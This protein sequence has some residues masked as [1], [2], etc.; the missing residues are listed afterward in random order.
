MDL[1][2]LVSVSWWMIIPLIVLG[3]ALHFVYDWSG[4]RRAVA[5]L[6][7][8]NESYWEHIKIAIW[9]IAL[10]QLVLFAAGGHNYAAFVP[11]ATIALYSVPISMVGIVFLYKAL[12][13]RNVLWVDI[14]VFALVVALAQ[15]I[16]IKLLGQLA[17]DAVTVL[18]AV[19]FLTGLVGAFLR[20][21][22][23]PPQEPDV[24]RDP[25]T[26]RYGL[27]G[28]SAAVADAGDD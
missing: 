3:S 21:T 10:T 26:G 4:Q 1:D 20:F 22:L 13:G 16:F 23:N 7:A 24:F 18:I 19:F 5:V 17:A 8:V 6:G 9:P 28:H 25:I 14:G 12:T 2:A 27:A 11:A 15:V